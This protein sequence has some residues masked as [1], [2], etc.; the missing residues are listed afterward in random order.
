MSAKIYGNGG[1]PP[2]LIPPVDHDSDSQATIVP[3]FFAPTFTL[4]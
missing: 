3:S 1:A 2:P 4:A